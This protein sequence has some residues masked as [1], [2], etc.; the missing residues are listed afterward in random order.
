MYNNETSYYIS[1]E[2]S[3]FHA[4][5]GFSQGIDDNVRIEEHYGGK[6]HEN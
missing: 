4:A 3:T 5:D 6:N 2:K 1:V